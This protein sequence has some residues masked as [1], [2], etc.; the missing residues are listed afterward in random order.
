MMRP[1]P[2][3]SLPWP[4]P[5]PRDPPL[6]SWFEF[7]P[8]ALFYAPVL[9]QAVL[10]ALRY[11][12]A[13]LLTAANPA[14]PSGGLCGESKTEILDQ[15]QGPERARIA[16]WTRLPP[17][18]DAPAAL[19]AMQAAGLRFP[20]VVKPDIGCNG[21]GVRQVADAETLARTLTAFPPDAAL[22]LQE[23][24]PAPL[25]AG[26]FYIREPGAAQGRISSITLKSPPEVVGDGRSSLRALIAADPRAGR[27][28]RLYLPRLGARADEVPPQGARVPLVFVGNHCRGSLFRDGTDHATPALTAAIE[29][30]A[31]SLPAFHFGRF[32][33]RFDQLA[34]LTRGEGFRVI[35]INGVGAEATHIWD[36]RTR[37]L[38]AWRV[39]LA[40]HAAAWRIGAANRAAGARPTGIRGLWRLWRRQTRLM[41]A[42]PESD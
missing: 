28:A 19:A 42:Y 29:R 39:Q 20:L 31:R 6:I 17:G 7:W 13:T 12:S 22:M 33:V 14:I 9:A 4:A 41:A 1:G 26:I 11:R 10:L 18:A 16:A 38:D 40:H 25:E 32:D 37:L 3:L 21:A 2:A 23:L 24:I 5:E 8:A 15:I 27:L 35:E 30:L 36:P 34:A